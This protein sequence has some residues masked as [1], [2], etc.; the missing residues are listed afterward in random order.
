MSTLSS[1]LGAIALIGILGF[2]AG[3]GLVVVAVSQGRPVRGG[4]ML[5][6]MGMVIFLL[7]SIASQGI[8]IVQPQETAVIFN[9]LTG[10]LEPPRERGTHI[11]IPVVQ[12][13][14]LYPIAQQQ[15]T[16]SGIPNEGAVIGNDAVRARTVDGQEIYLDI[17]V[18]YSIDP[19]NVNTLHTNWQRRYQDDFL[20]PTVRG[21]I[22]EAVTNFRAEEIYGERRSE[23]ESSI[24]TEMETRMTVQ[25]LV[26]TD[27]LIRDVTFSDEFTRSIEEKL[28]ADQEAQRAAFRV[29]QEQQEAERVRVTA[30]GQRDAAIS[31]AEGEAQAIVLRA[32]AEAEA[33]RLVSEQIA[34]NPSLIQYEYI[35]KLSDNVSLAVIPSNSPFLFDFGSLAEP[36]ADFVPPIVPDVPLPEATIEDEGTDTGE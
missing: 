32:K 25:G 34:A 13:A 19:V 2:I 9:V 29:Q 31:E 8:I 11:I 6:A 1:L 30:Q 26:L 21:V 15:Y 36:N 22:R 3:V 24:Q 5:A 14:T 23:L 18:I 17:T 20:R 10:E 28:I 12:E 4:V 27:L 16:M 33:L 35:Q 7:F